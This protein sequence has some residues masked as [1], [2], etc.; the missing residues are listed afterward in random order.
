MLYHAP[1][2][3]MLAFC[4]LNPKFRLFALF[5]YIHLSCVASARLNLIIPIAPHTSPA[6][7]HPT[8]VYYTCQI[9]MS[10]TNTDGFWTLEEFFTFY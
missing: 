8:I 10:C 6:S 3:R 7:L 4:W 2:R 9:P 1:W 5:L